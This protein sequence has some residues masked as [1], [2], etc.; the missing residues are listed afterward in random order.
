VISVARESI[1]DELGIN[2]GAP[3]LGVV[4][5]FEHHDARALAHHKP[6]PITVVRAGRTFRRIIE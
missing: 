2:P 5:G 1:A 6:V 4:I 3:A